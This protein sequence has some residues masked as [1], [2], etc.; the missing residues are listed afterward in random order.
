M[1]VLKDTMGKY[2]ESWDFIR[3]IDSKIGERQS[4]GRLG[5]GALKIIQM[6]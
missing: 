6:L 5:R 1:I 4:A 2:G 3:V